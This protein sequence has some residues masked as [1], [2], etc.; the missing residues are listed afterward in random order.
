MAQCIAE[1]LHITP[2]E[3]S[4]LSTGAL[5]IRL[6][7]ATIPNAVWIQFVLLKMGMSRIIV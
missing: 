5:C 7:R 2:V 3:S 6:Q 4:L 1:V